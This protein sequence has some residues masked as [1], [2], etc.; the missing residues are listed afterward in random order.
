MIHPRAG[1]ADTQTKSGF[2]IIKEDRRM[3]A[4][5]VTWTGECVWASDW[6]QGLVLTWFSGKTHT[7]QSPGVME[8]CS[9]DIWF[10]REGG[11]SLLEMR[12]MR[13][14]ALKAQKVLKSHKGSVLPGLGKC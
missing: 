2:C 9:T 4:G 10:F 1:H 14:R 5:K 3:V 6:Y 8:W 11:L 13:S 7:E 12:Q